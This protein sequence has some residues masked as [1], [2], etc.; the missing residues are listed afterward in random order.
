MN[1]F[2]NL[3]ENMLCP[4]KIQTTK[5]ITIIVVL[6]QLIMLYGITL[7]FNSVVDHSSNLI[8]DAKR[9]T[10]GPVRLLWNPR[11]YLGIFLLIVGLVVHALLFIFA[12]TPMLSQ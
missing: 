5:S 6:S 10:L 12:P 11:F 4:L 8:L 9:D 1:I 2:A 3:L 7:I